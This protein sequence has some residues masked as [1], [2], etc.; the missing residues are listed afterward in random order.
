MYSWDIAAADL[1]WKGTDWNSYTNAYVKQN[2]QP[3][4][5]LVGP[6]RSSGRAQ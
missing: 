2:K 4:E 1:V 3:R 5:R 6:D